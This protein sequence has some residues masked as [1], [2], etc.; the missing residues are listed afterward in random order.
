MNGLLAGSLFIVWA[1]C[2]TIG[3]WWL[4]HAAFKLR[5][6]EEGIVGLVVGLAAEVGVANFTA[7]VVPLPWTN[8]LSALVVL[9]AGL[10]AGLTHGGL[11]ALK[12]KIVPGQWVLFII[13]TYLFF[14]INRGMAIYD[15][16]AH[17]PTLSLMATGQIPPHFAYD[18]LATYGYHYFVLLV[19]AQIMRL[20]NWQPWVAWDLARAVT[21][22]P[23][24]ILGG[25]WAYRVIQ[26]RIAGLV[27]GLAVLFLSG[28]RWLLLFLPNTVLTFLGSRV[29]LIGAGLT[30]G[31]TLVSSLANPWLFE[32]QGSFPFPFAFENGI[33]NSGAESGHNAIGLMLVAVLFALLLTSTRWKNPWSVI[34]SIMLISSMGLLN[35][36]VLPIL[37]VTFS[38][39]TIVWSLRRH[40]FKLPL[41]LKQWWLIWIVSG[42]IIAFQGGV[43]T[44]T[45][46]GVLDKLLGHVQPA[47]Y[48]M[49]EF[50][51]AAPAI[52]SSQLGVLSLVNI[53]SL[54]VALAEIGPVVLLLPLLG[55]WAWKAIRAQRWF[56]ATL[57]GAAIF[58]LLLVF[59][60]FTGSTGVGNGSRLY[61]F[62]TVGTMMAVSIAWMWGSHRRPFIKWLVGFLG[63]ITL[64]GGFV[65]LGVQLPNIKNQVYSYFLTSP[66]SRMESLYWNKL[67][68]NSLVFD[69]VPSR[70]VT[71]FGRY[72]DAGY[73]WYIKK[74][75]FINLLETP[76]PVKMNSAGFSY[77]YLDQQYWENLTET[78]RKKFDQP[79]VVLL[80]EETQGLI[81]RK[82]F[83]IRTC[84]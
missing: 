84:K 18:P 78:Q 40:S 80:H 82:L 75:S 48:F 45:L 12:L 27:G 65:M 44:V 15:D 52:V 39:L 20:A 56:E 38:L 14:Q 37:A 69:P 70:G 41:A 53:G 61:F 35:E 51:L 8:W 77:A 49:L 2:W 21:L 74:P 63:G 29:Q 9:L 64:F 55:W 17:L 34:V 60:R 57:M 67:E 54:L 43:W 11:P 83:D 19:G 16:Y 42:A 31:P 59:V 62:V 66:D 23:A 10:I 73:S 72:T 79:C 24:V 46:A 58:S 32:G 22:A 26:K 4:V 6:E 76:D 47:S 1:L 30:A 71:V 28:T 36:V 33:F 3:G 7:R 50:Q 13:L 81:W 25:L 68:P 5:P